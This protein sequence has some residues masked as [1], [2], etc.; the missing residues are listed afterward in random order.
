[1]SRGTSSGADDVFCLK[2]E[3]DVLLS[4]NGY[5]VDIEQSILRKPLYATDFTR[6]NFRPISRERI[7]FPYI[8]T[9]DGYSIIEENILRKDYPKTYKY[10]SSNRKILESRKQFRVW[11]GY[12]APRNLNVHDNADLLVP[13]LAD[14][15]LFSLVSD[16]PKS[17]CLMASAGFSVSVLPSENNVSPKYVLGIVN[18]KLLFWLLKSISNKF[19]GGWITCTKQYFGKLPIRKIDFS[20]PAD[21]ERHDR[22]VQLVQRMLDL[23]KNFAAAQTPNEKTALQRQIQTTDRQIDKLVYELYHLT[24][25]EIKIV[26]ESTEPNK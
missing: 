20:D 7:I 17:F 8:V 15:G 21:R 18:S 23:H 6:Y 10:L 3:S 19:R 14:R 9:H 2:F 22:M 25:N 11:Y 13:L 16:N 26:E 24:D 4:R 12:S 1:M 5:A